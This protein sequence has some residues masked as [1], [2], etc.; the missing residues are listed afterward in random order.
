MKTENSIQNLTYYL[1]ELFYAKLRMYSHLSGSHYLLYFIETVIREN[2]NIYNLS[3]TKDI[4][5]M[6]ANYYKIND[7][8]VERSIRT[9]IAI[10]WKNMNDDVKK[11]IFPIIYERPTNSEY[12]YAIYDYIKALYTDEQEYYRSSFL[13]QQYLERDFKIY[14]KFKILKTHILT[15]AI[16]YKIKIG[17]LTETNYKLLI[18]Y[19]DDK[20]GLYNGI[21]ITKEECIEVTEVINILFKM[22]QY[23]YD[24]DNNYP[25]PRNKKY[26]KTYL[27]KLPN[28][29]KSK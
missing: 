8:K 15:D 28:K 21:V 1:D 18:K 25:N 20:Y 23:I 5:P 17:E 16:M 4:Y 10:S 26:V 3:P 6:I 9:V 12:I 24:I 2:I 7:K 14:T 11:T 27:E 22:C 19:L 29:I 13:V